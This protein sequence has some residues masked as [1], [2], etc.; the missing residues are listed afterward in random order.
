[1]VLVHNNKS[2]TQQI[3]TKAATVLQKNE[4]EKSEEGRKEKAGSAKKKIDEVKRS[5]NKSNKLVP[6]LIGFCI[7]FLTGF[8]WLLLKGSAIKE[9][10]KEEVQLAV[11]GKERNEGEQKLLNTFNDTLNNNV[12]DLKMAGGNPIV[13]S[14]SININKDSLLIIGN[15]AT[16]LRDS[17]YNGPA[18]IL[19]PQCSYILLDSIIIENFDVAILVNNRSLH[20][21]NVQFRKCRVPVQYQ[22]LYPLNTFV[23]GHLDALYYKIDSSKNNPAKR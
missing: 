1:V 5:S 3:A 9:D 16:L 7:I 14:D 19:S 2:P 18:L 21:K 20:L 15:G 4:S 6:V 22:F 8:L 13:I 11:P 17:S 12:F 23:T 10:Q